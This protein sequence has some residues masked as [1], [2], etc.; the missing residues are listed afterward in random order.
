M[1]YAGAYTQDS[2]KS[3]Y[4]EDI[5][6]I[7][8]PN[9][10]PKEALWSIR[11]LKFEYKVVSWDLLSDMIWGRTLGQGSNYLVKLGDQG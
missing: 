10:G 5:K 3:I 4:L 6:L 7:M 11:F 2:S 8:F 9:S 1:K